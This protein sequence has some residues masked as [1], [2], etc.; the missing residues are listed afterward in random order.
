MHRIDANSATPEKKFTEGSPS[1][2]VPATV[3]TADWL[4][5]VQENICY[6]IEQRGLVLQKGDKTQLLQ[7]IIS[8]V[9]PTTPTG[10][11]I[12]Q[13]SYFGQSN[14]P[15]GWMKCNGAAVSRSVYANLFAAIGVTYGS[16]DGST[17]FNLPDARGR[18]VRT[19]DDGKGIDSSRKIGSTQ[20]SQNLAHTHTSTFVREK[21]NA[22]F[23]PGTGGNAV[24]GDQMSA[25]TQNIVTTSSGGG[26][27]RPNNIAFPL[28][29]KY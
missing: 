22:D 20:G 29:I 18:F 15:S 27:A 26:E 12:G 28:F 16:G 8:A 3:V 21:I 2:S 1:G 17:T 23:V 9:Q 7:A 19:L 10:A 24:L 5:D 6:V 14:P 4:N 25:G 13:M 11:D